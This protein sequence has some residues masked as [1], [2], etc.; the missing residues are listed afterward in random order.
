M[1][2]PKNIF[3]NLT[4][5]VLTAILSGV[6][7]GHFFPSTAVQME[8]LGKTFIQIVKLF[9]APIILLT[10]TIGISNMGD[11]KKVGRVGVKSILYFEVVTTFALLIGIV[12][13]YILQ[14]GEGVAV[15]HGANT[16]I[17]QYQ[18]KA[19]SFSWWQFFKDNFTIQ[20]LLFSVLAGTL[21]NLYPHKSKIIQPLTQASK[22]VFK[23]LHMVMYLAPIGALEAWHLPSAS[24]ESKL[25]CL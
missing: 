17:Q 19:H 2:S 20:I 10:I 3:K 24:M 23:A 11:L 5:W 6:I 25:F 8:L 1:N 13:A 12:V 7:L 18:E 21:L 14:P 9:I 22:Y 16:S 4:F 15:G